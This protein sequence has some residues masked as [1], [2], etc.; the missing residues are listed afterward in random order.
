MKKIVISHNI[1]KNVSYFK[2]S[3]VVAKGNVHKNIKTRSNGL[4]DVKVSLT[5]LEK[6]LSLPRILMS[7]N[8]QRVTVIIF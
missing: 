2:S 4:Y 5:N 3:S 6:L 7:I 1:F 8:F